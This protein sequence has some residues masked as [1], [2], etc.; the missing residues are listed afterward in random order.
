MLKNLPGKMASEIIGAATKIV[1][2][3]FTFF[4]TGRFDVLL[5]GC[6]A[7]AGIAL[8]YGRGAVT[9]SDAKTLST[10]R[11]LPKVPFVALLRRL[12]KGLL[13]I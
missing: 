3:A 7:A 13:Q 4:S 5:Q 12:R 6:T 1:T 8:D 2:G 10:L 9:S 11:L